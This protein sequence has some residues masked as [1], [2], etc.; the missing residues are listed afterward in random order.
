[1]F[2]SIWYAKKLGRRLLQNARKAKMQKVGVGYFHLL[3]VEFIQKNMTLFVVLFNLNWLAK[4]GLEMERW[5][6]MYWCV[7]LFKFVNAEKQ[8]W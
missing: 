8:L 6:E 2:A 5:K 1:M 4:G 7:F 3:R